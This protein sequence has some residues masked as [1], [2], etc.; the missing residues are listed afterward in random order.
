MRLFSFFVSFL[1]FCNVHA[2]PDS[3]TGKWNAIVRGDFGFVIAH[4]PALEPLQERHVK[5]FEISLTKQY[6]GSSYWQ[7][8]YLYPDYGITLAVFELGTDKLG[9]GIAVYPFIDFPL[10]KKG[11]HRL[12]F[13][14][15]MGLGYVEKTFDADDNIKNSAIG[16]H[17]NGVIHFDLHYAAGISKRTTLEFGPAIT[18][19]SNGSY[20]LPN[21]GINIA[22]FN[23]GFQHSFGSSRPLQHPEIIEKDKAP[24][25]HVY[26]G[27]FF[28]RVY[29]PE[30]RGYFAMTLSGLWYKPINLKSAFG[31]GADL[32]YDNSLV[33]R[34]DKLGE[35]ESE[36]IDNFRAGLYGAYE[37]STGRLAIAFNMGF[38]L[39]NAW[40]ND[41]SIYHRL[42]LR[43][44]FEKWYACLNL[45]TH[46]ARADFIELGAGIRLNTK[47]K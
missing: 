5:G 42:G 11:F 36:P 47:K 24:E 13:R 39:Y 14:F 7:S 28:K 45:K 6:D 34:I 20:S 10:G 38:Y 8:A 40:Q 35:E 46:Y 18:H 32:F 30:G 23:L 29:P 3:T 26:T 41:G 2:A 25:I 37:L 9:T 31:A 44:Y 43:Y 15:G 16:S 1:F 33:P 4:R 27:G 19:F 21:L 12:H 17:V 22:T